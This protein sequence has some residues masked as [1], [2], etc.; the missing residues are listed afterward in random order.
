MHRGIDAPEACGQ[1]SGDARRVS[2]QGN[3]ERERE[4]EGCEQR[5]LPH[6]GMVSPDPKRA[7]G[8]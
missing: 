7:T 5:E 6:T 8:R 3:P 2:H 4:A 1:D